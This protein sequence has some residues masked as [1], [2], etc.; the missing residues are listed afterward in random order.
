MKT[1]LKSVLK[2]YI[3]IK[4]NKRSESVQGGLG[5]ELCA[6]NLVLTGHS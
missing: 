5:L 1:R 6:Y 2:L 3:N 4:K